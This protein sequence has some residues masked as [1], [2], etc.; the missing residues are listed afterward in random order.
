MII[1]KCYKCYNFDDGTRV[2]M[3]IGANGPK[4][5][6]KA[7]A[8]ED[9]SNMSDTLYHGSKESYIPNEVK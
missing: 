2:D 8:C 6:G 4:V 3:S 1:L 5:P 7:S 9:L